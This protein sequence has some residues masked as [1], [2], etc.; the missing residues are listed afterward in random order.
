MRKVCLILL[1]SNLIGSVF[2][3]Y[4][5]AEMSVTFDVEANDPA[6]IEFGFSAGPDGQNRIE[7]FQITLGN[8]EDENTNVVYAYWNVISTAS[9]DLSLYCEPLISDE[10]NLLG[11]NV[12]WMSDE[13]DYQRIGGED[14]YGSENSNVIFT[15]IAKEGE[16][17][18]AVGSK[19]LDIAVFSDAGQ[20]AGDYSG[21]LVLQMESI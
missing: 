20:K 13:S 14:E 3:T 18:A 19:K 6:Y 17:L 21:H 8:N 10:G 4:E 11:W 2:A 5:P 12:T 7:E 1:I 15:R 16:P 9:F